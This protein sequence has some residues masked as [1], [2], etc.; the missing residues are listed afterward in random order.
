MIHFF[1]QINEKQL[2]QQIYTMVMVTGD[3]VKEK[4]GE[5]KGLYNKRKQS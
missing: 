4:G 5:G 2:N 1:T 3:Q